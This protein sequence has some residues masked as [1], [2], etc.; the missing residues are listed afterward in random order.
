[1]TGRTRFER[2]F[3]L[4]GFPALA[5]VTALAFGLVPE[6]V[7]GAGCR[8]GLAMGTQI[9]C[10]GFMWN[11]FVVGAFVGVVGPI[12]GTYVVYREMALIGETLAHSAFAGVAFGTLILGTGGWSAGLLLAALV[13]AIV[14]AAGVQLLTDRTDEGGDVPIAIALTGSFAVGALFLDVGGGF[15]TVDIG[16]YLFGSISLT[17]DRSVVLMA[18]LS[19]AVVGTVA[20]NYK[21][22]LFVTFDE[23][24]ARVAGF[25]VSR[26]NLLLVVLTAVVV[27]GAM[28]ILGVILVAAMLVVPVAAAAQIAGSFRSALYGSVIVGEA[29]VFAG[30]ALAWTYG[31]RPG[32]V[33]VVVAITIYLVAVVVG[34]RI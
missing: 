20:L 25:P 24:A 15:A 10:F 32:A 27:V 23:R 19:L 28:R 31:L 12:V 1:M 17:D 33:I 9:A 3:P 21:Q 8:A 4:V 34:N 22:L 16:S 7:F 2:L 18:L 13:A 29:S 26:Y 6:G 11:A 5:A 30:I 14:G